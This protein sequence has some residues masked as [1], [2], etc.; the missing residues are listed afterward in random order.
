MAVLASL[1]SRLGTIA[2]LQLYVHTME[3]TL[4]RSHRDLQRF[5]DF[6]VRKAAVD[7]A[8]HFGFALC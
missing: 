8:K 2:H 4:D 7:K 3:M 5:R 6:P 1:G